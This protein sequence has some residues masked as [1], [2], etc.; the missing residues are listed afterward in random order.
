MLSPVDSFKL[1]KFGWCAL[2]DQAENEHIE[3]GG[4][5]YHFESYD[6]QFVFAAKSSCRFGRT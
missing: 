1:G 3:G 2:C 6:L 5:D 4:G